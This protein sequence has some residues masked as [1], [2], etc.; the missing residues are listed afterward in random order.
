MNQVGEGRDKKEI[1]KRNEK[2]SSDDKNV[3]LF[4]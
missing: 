1:D 3:S 2:E 4:D